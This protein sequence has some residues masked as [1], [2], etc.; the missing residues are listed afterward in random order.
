MAKKRH[1]YVPKAYLKSFCDEQENI[2]LYLKD[3]P[4]KFIHQSPNNVGFHKYYYSQP[5]PE[6][7]K[8]HDS[9]EDLFSEVESR[10]PGIVERIRQR[11]D[12]NNSLEDI[13]KF[14]ALQRVR[15]PASRDA[16]EAM[17]AEH[18]KS[19]AR[20]LDATGKLP[21]KPK[22]LEDILDRV[23][24]SINPHQSIH[25]MV[26]MVEGIGTLFNQIGIGALHN[27]TGMPFLTSDNPV[28]WFDP[29][30]PELEMRP[31]G[32]QPGGPIVL[33][34]PIAPSVLIYGHSSMR[35]PF[36]AEG[37]KHG[38]LTDVGKALSMNRSICRFAYQV[39]IAQSGGQEALIRKH[40][41]ESPVL[42]T[43]TIKDKDGEMLI[44]QSVFGKR[45]RKPKWEGRRGRKE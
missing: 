30:V 28:I 44:H 43:T 25:A 35:D 42:K 2:R 21:P 22:G 14:I 29:S 40:A 31:Y 39:V 36:A 8:D 41:G 34:F 10:W 16:S 33:L 7:G 15:V 17:S 27:M 19:T 9:L 5:V 23:V 1:H 13:F 11:E 38:D 32:L 4:D 6:G 18:V 37:F 24:V 3:D 20:I 45:R 12:V 26:H